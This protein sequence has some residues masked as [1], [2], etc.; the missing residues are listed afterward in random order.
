MFILSLNKPVAH[1]TSVQ[2]E[3][4]NIYAL[5]HDVTS[6]TYKKVSAHEFNIE[7]NG[8]KI[9]EL[10][11]HD[12]AE[13]DHLD[14]D[15]IF[16]NLDTLSTDYSISRKADKEKSCEYSREV[17]VADHLIS[18]ALLEFTYFLE[19]Y[20]DNSHF[21]VINRLYEIIELKENPL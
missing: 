12:Y 8:L 17:L 13:P 20:L 15:Q 14:I 5:L 21:T 19:G 4:I 3:A 10:L 11:L 16:K 18:L 2:I 9:A 6:E 1:F 7:E